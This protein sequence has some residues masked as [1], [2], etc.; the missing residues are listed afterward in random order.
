M[1]ANE[2]MLLDDDDFFIAGN[3]GGQFANAR[4]E[5]S[6]EGGG[7]MDME[8]DLGSPENTGNFKGN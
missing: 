5:Q 4:Y 3:K 8:M 1:N 2:E 6:N 7:R